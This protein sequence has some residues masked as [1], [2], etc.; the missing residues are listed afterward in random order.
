MLAS[1]S[2]LGVAVLLLHLW[3]THSFPTSAC[4]VPC[5][6]QHGPLLNCSSLGL[7]EIP[8]HIPATAVSL[9]LSNNALRSLG[10]LSFGHVKLKGLLHL[11]VGINALESLSLI[12]KKDRSGTRTRSSREQECTSW[13]PDLQL[14]SAERNHLKHLP[15]GLGCMKS[16]QILQLSYNHISKIGLTDLDNCINLKELHLQHNSIISIHP[17][18]FIDL[19]LLQVLDLSYNMLVTIPVPAYQ[20][21][22]NTLV[23]VSFNRWKRDC[24]LQALR[25][26]IS[27]DTEMGDT[28]W[29]VVCASPPHH[30]GKDLLH[31]KDS[32]LTCP[33]N[34][35]STSGRYH[36]MI[37]DEGMQISIPCSNDSQDIMQVHWWTPH[38]QVTDNQPKILIKDITEQHAGLYICIS[39]LQGGAHINKLWRRIQSKR[40]STPPPPPPTASSTGPQPY[41]NEGY[42][43]VEDQ[44][45]EVR[46]GS[47]VSFG[48]I[49]EVEDQVPYYVTGE[50]D[51]A[52][53]SSE[54][55]TEAQT[56]TGLHLKDQMYL[57]VAKRNTEM[58]ALHLRKM[59]DPKENIT[60]E[61]LNI[62]PKSQNSKDLEDWRVVQDTR[63]QA[64]SSEEDVTLML[65]K[66]MSLD[67][68]GASLDK[69]STRKSMK[70]TET[71]L[72][73]PATRESTSSEEMFRKMMALD[74]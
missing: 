23:D 14:L 71:E 61:Q 17:H 32:E 53:G 33:T 10:S 62:L 3:G 27:F 15:K 9:N 56:K 67:K 74:K 18:A 51:Q 37:V 11:W 22:R 47:T 31:L 72:K 30:G 39:G 26:W 8:T 50:N 55:N 40:R 64:T 2:V 60:E 73:Q 44:E 54:S 28:S 52:D 41:V 68:L 48:E 49:T 66:T 45:R 36:N 59:L 42:C 43:D 13:A 24:N 21:L 35:Y 46:V 19:K 4:P 70:V 16:L 63:N 34:E 57:L 65:R 38:G 25:R 69:N 12:L 1:S 29:Q 5:L 6:C 58:G 7:T 20:S